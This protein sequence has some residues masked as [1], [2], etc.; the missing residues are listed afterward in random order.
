MKTEFYTGGVLSA[1][2]YFKTHA[3]CCEI[4]LDVEANYR[5]ARPAPACSDHGSPAF[6]DPGDPSEFEILSVKFAGTKGHL[7]DM[8]WKENDEFEDLVGNA[9]DK[10]W[11][12]RQQ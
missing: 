12:C 1:T 4:A 9:L 3:E 8:Y 7:A 5:P 11:E 10:E 2:V 6:S